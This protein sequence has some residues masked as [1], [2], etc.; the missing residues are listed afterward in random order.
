MITTT[1]E[2]E[3]GA[4][5]STARTK[6]QTFRPPQS[7]VAIWVPLIIVLLLAMGL[8]YG[9]WHHIQVKRAQEDFAQKTSAVSVEF[10][11]AL[12][13]AKP[14][15]LVLPA[16]VTAAQETTIFARANGYVERW[17]VDLGDNVKE[18]QLL[19]VI[20]TPEVDQELAQA[21]QQL[22]QAEADFELARVSAQRWRELT[23]KMVV[24]KQD[25]DTRQQQY[26][27]ATGAVKAA[28]ANVDRLVE[29]TGF[30][31]V[32]APFAG[33]ITSRKIDVGTLLTAGGGT[34]GTPL[35][36][37]AQ[38]NPLDIYVNVPQTY[39]GSIRIGAEV[40][41]MVPEFPDQA[42]KGK[43]IRSAGAIDPTSRTLLTEVEV[44]NP[45][46]TLYAGMYAQVKFTFRDRNTPLIIPAN[47]FVFRTEGPQVAT[48]GNDNKV[49]W[50][51]IEVGRDYGK[52][53]EVTKG[54]QE[55]Q[56]V[57][58]NPTDDLKEG[59]EVQ[60]KAGQFEQKDVTASK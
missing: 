34:G 54:L 44:P 42:F 7:R 13:N 56:K 43:I 51:G 4:A 21:R 52:D 24:S 27:S 41:L 16:N 30:K 20:A 50:Q 28:Q 5:Q 60:A 55:N 6:P 36:T 23:E 59:S 11:P 58:L 10:V 2:H 9:I 12:R 37:L 40:D 26:Q 15:D 53:M 17:L 14:R 38:T 29:T 46:N 39:V 31:N 49:H 19:A 57:I 32:V 22:N 3:Q 48:L 33:T 47:A 18:G 45:N 25:N 35:Y 1:Q 8:I